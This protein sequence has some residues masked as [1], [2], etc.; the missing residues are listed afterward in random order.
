MFD[1]L[2]GEPTDSLLLRDRRNNSSRERCV[3]RIVEPDEVA[4]ASDHGGGGEEPDV[5]GLLGWD[6][7]GHFVGGVLVYSFI[8]L[9][10]IGDLGG[11]E[12]GGGWERGEGR[13]EF[14]EVDDAAARAALSLGVA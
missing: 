12:G 13:L 5:G 9:D 4:V 6:C 10:G 7:G 14:G 11:W 8:L 1:E 2:R 3:Q